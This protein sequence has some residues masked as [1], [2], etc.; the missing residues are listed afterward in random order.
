[1]LDLRIKEQPLDLARYGLE[2]MHAA[3]RDRHPSLPEKP[4]LTDYVELSRRGNLDIHDRELV[5]EAVRVVNQEIRPSTGTI[6]STREKKLE[7]GKDL[8]VVAKPTRALD[9]TAQETYPTDTL[10]GQE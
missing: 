9:Q 4:T 7:L 3:L 1:M 8:F 5:E 10:V 6:F 2:D